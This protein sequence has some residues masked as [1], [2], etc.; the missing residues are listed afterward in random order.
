MTT[1]LAVFYGFDSIHRDQ[2]TT[3]FKGSGIECLFFGTIRHINYHQKSVDFLEAPGNTGNKS[4]SSQ[5]LLDE[6]INSIVSVLGDRK[7][8][9]MVISSLN[10]Q[11]VV[12]SIGG[13][14]SAWRDGL[15]E[16]LEKPLFLSTYLLRYLAPEAR[17]L[18]LFNHSSF[19]PLIGKSTYSVSQYALR[20]AVNIL[21]MERP[22]TSISSAL[23]DDDSLGFSVKHQSNKAGPTIEEVVD[24]TDSSNIAM[25]LKWLLLKTESEVFSERQWDSRDRDLQTLWRESWRPH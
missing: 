22:E 9:F 16:H 11:G 20:M 18:F 3:S 23:I 7:I 10:D 12:G 24:Q 19:V 2:L 14:Y 13:D 17:L 1:K 6:E 4:K 15:F 21:S 8:S 5:E 25:F